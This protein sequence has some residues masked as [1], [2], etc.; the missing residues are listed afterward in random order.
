MAV[1]A[2]LLGDRAVRCTVSS[3]D[4]ALRLRRQIQ[5]LELPKVENVVAGWAAVVV[6]F[7]TPGSHVRTFAEVA[8]EL[9]LEQASTEMGRRHELEISYDGPDLLEVARHTGL[10]PDEVAVRHAARDYTVAFLGFSPGF[11]YLAGLDP[12]LATPRRATPRVRIDAGSVGIADE[13]TGIYPSRLP[14]GWQLIG[15]VQVT[16]FDA[17]RAQPTLLEPGDVVR[18]VQI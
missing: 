16:L 3:V 7:E 5:R 2:S 13:A 18:F 1:T 6:I 15:H 10:S 12:R 4:E 9:R 11:P 14:G 17:S 8:V